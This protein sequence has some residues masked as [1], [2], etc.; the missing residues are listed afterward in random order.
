MPDLA[1]LAPLLILLAVL[2]TAAKAFFALLIVPF[3]PYDVEA[4][5]VFIPALTALLKLVLRLTGYL[6]NKSDGNK[7]GL[8]L[9]PSVINL[10]NSLCIA[11]A[12]LLGSIF[13]TIGDSATTS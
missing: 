10:S 8:G 6:R 4:F 2:V 13:C 5:T 12:N 3:L 11:G 1:T 7:L 9:G